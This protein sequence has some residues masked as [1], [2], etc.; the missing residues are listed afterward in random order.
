[1]ILTAINS[2]IVHLRVETISFVPVPK[3]IF[4]FPT[5]FTQWKTSQQK[6]RIRDRL[7]HD[8][9]DECTD[10]QSIWFQNIYFTLKINREKQLTSNNL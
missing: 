9:T 6:L 3:I 8:F 7:H 2:N 4:P 10:K 1:M 5:L